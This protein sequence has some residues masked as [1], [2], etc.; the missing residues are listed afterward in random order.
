[1]TLMQALRQSKFLARCVLAWFVLSMAV[2]VA[3]P[4]VSPQAS[5][6]VCSSS[7][8]VKLVNAGA[9]DSAPMQSHVLDCVLCL[10]SGAPPAQTV[11]SLDSPDLLSFALQS[12]PSAWVAKRSAAPLLARGPPSA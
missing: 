5:Q 12:A 10:V 6:L 8:A 4:V 11:Q 7:G 2:A 1:M 9:D 3:A